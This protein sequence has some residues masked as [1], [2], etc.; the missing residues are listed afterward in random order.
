MGRLFGTDGIRGVANEYPMIPEMAEKIGRAI[1][2]LLKGDND[3]AQVLV[4]R[5]TRISGEMLEQALVSGIRSAGGD[6]YLTGPLPTPGVCYIAEKMGVDA[7]VVISASHNPFP[8]NGIKIFKGDGFKLTDE[9]ELQIERLVLENDTPV[10][11]VEANIIGEES[12]ISDAC[13]QYVDFLKDT[14]SEEEIFGGLNAVL[15]CSNGATFQAAPATFIE[16]GATVRTLFA[17]PDGRNIN[18]NCGSEYPQGL[19]EVVVR[20]KA[21]VGLA[22]DGDG[23]RVTA[24]DETGTILTGGQILAICAKQLKEEGRLTNNVVVSTVMSNIGLKLVLDDLS[25]DLVTTQVGDKHVLRDMLNKGAS[26]GGEDSGHMIFL[27]H[28]K[29]GDGVLTALML[30]RAMKKTGTPLSELAGIMKVFPQC[31]V[32]VEVK[33]K[34]PIADL[35]RIVAVIRDVEKALRTGGRVLVRYSGTQP[36]CRVMVE[37]PTDQETREYCERIADVV[38]AELG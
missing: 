3:K 34:L 32:N 16:L 25:I 21:N 1:V 29:T 20:E 4:G 10:P 6:A 23:D 9:M 35:P 26:I 33:K 11:S 8:D 18:L 36:L 12:L 22:F 30:V 31:L 13:S 7:G 28:H 38:R 19:A 17:E 24:V 27:D 2:H 14:V 37:G 5:D 15:D